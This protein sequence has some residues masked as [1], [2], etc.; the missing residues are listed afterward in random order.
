MLCTRS[1]RIAVCFGQRNSDRRGSRAGG[2][3]DIVGIPFTV[4][5]NCRH[6]PRSWKYDC[7]V[8]GKV[9]RSVIFCFGAS[10]IIV[11]E[12]SL[13]TNPSPATPEKKTKQI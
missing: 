13:S 7:S 9:V 4:Y 11:W 8:L 12:A 6:I 5:K 1:I 2:L 10:P 3:L